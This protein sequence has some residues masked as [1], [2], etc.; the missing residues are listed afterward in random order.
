L[1][2]V[3]SLGF[4]IWNFQFAFPFSLVSREEKIHHEGTKAQGKAKR[5]LISLALIRNNTMIFILASLAEFMKI[6]AFVEPIISKCATT[7][8]KFTT[9]Y[10]SITETPL[11][12]SRLLCVLCG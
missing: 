10:F 6:R 4:G 12:F 11:R 2:F 9:P 3:Q 5:F 1:E 7:D 8:E